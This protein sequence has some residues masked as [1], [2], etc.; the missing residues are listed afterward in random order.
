[1]PDDRNWAF[2]TT[3]PNP[4]LGTRCAKRKAEN[5]NWG[6]S[7]T[8]A[9]LVAVGAICTLALFPVISSAQNKA[10]SPPPIPASEQQ[11]NPEKQPEK[12]APG[13]VAEK[14]PL[15]KKPDEKGSNEPASPPDNPETTNGDDTPRP[16]DAETAKPAE[17]GSQESWTNDNGGKEGPKPPGEQPEPPADTD[18][19]DKTSE[20]KVAE[21]TASKSGEPGESG[22]AST[23]PDGNIAEA[24]STTPDKPPES[25]TP[26]PVSKPPKIPAANAAENRPTGTRANN[27]A[28][29]GA[30]GDESE[31]AEPPEPHFSLPSPAEV[32]GPVEGYIAPT[33]EP[34]DTPTLEIAPERLSTDTFFQPSLDYLGRRPL[35]DID[36]EETSEE[37]IARSFEESLKLIDLAQETRPDTGI[38]VPLPSGVMTFKASDAFEFDRRNMVLKFIGNAELVFDNIAIWADLIEVDDGAA[39]A[40]AKG[41]VGIQEKDEI[42]FCDEAYLNYDTKTLELFWVEGNSGGPDIEGAVFFE[43]ERAY[44]SFDELIME[45]VKITTCEPYCGGPTEMHMEAEKMKYKRGKSIVLYNA[46][47]YARNQKFFYVP[48]FAFPLDR[49]QPIKQGESDLEQTYGYQRTQG[50]FAKFAYTYSVRYAENVKRAL[51][52]VAKLELSEKQG[53]GLGIR[54]DFL[55]PS[56]GVATVVGFYQQGWPDNPLQR[57]FFHP[58]GGGT[59]AGFLSGDDF[60]PRNNKPNFRFNLKQELNLSR[61]LNGSLSIERTDD[62]V[63]AT[64]QFRSDTRN[65]RWNNRLTLNYGKHDTTASISGS[66]SITITGGF[67]DSRDGT[68]EPSSERA[69]SNAAVRYGTKIS[70]ELKFS[71]S[72]DYSASKGSTGSQNLP[73][74]Q[75]GTLRMGLDWTGKRDSELEGYSARLGYLE[76]GID[77]D[78]DNNT[79]DRNRNIRK[80]LPS[81]EI[82]L[83]QDLFNDGAY[84]N[85]FTI[86]IE[87]LVTGRRRTPES[88]FRAKISARGQDRTEL[89]HSS[90]FNTSLSAEQYWYDDGNAQYTL[91]PRFNYSYN[92]KSWWKFGANWSMQYRQGVRLPPVQGDRKTYFN[93]GGINFSMSNYRSWRWELRSGYDFRDHSTS[94]VSSKIYWDPNRTFGITQTMT[95]NIRQHSFNS[96]Q[97]SGYFRS[98]YVDENGYYNWLFKLTLNNDINDQFKATRIDLRWLKRW[99]NGWTSDVQG[100]YRDGS[101]LLP[102]VSSNFVRDYIKRIAV[103]KTTCC[104]TIECVWRTGIN[105]FEVKVYLNALPQYPSRMD[106]FKILDDEWETDT[107]FPANQLQQDILQDMFGINQRL[108]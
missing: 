12:D 88:S 106:N 60:H 82:R 4:R 18:V 46:Y 56:L 37:E 97:L 79:T 96:S 94:P 22:E 45:K 17:A 89:S 102:A 42:L 3:T 48:M 15:E 5:L 16:K 25:S 51:L 67:T 14:A 55:I 105:S 92:P 54:Q 47:F 21:T 30:D 68:Q 27:A 62:V 35:P 107:F 91:Q 83:P 61:S 39:T 95:Y 93:R 43:A 100:S 13:N 53:P 72:Q 87:N 78:Q 101:D 99:G 98:P 59:F 108:F 7:C 58:L 44:G 28:E 80:E 64:N 103:R 2:R 1:M 52:G 8:S 63:A 73:A 24:V 33:G 29:A 19:T 26:P 70:K 6:K 65:N 66:Q 9:W 20:T 41:F 23:T 50:W 75:E 57:V 84:F 81:L 11:A 34:L 76:Q 40:Y 69:N 10:E 85:N 49:R 86:N 31:V 36:I 71:F 32:A 104:T 90:F 38:K 74:D 77:Y